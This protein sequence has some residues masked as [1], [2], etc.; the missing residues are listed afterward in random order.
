VIL[1]D[2][3]GIDEKVKVMVEVEFAKMYALSGSIQCGKLQMTGGSA[4]Q[5]QCRVG[6]W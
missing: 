3:R 4:R 2:H 6:L 1:L 5:M